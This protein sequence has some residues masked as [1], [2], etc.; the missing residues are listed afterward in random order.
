MERECT[1]DN[2]MGYV[3]DK[4]LDMRGNLC[5]RCAPQNGTEGEYI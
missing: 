4:R 1:E 2:N 5:M 3:V